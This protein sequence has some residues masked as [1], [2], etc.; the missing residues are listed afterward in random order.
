MVGYRN[1]QTL[2]ALN[3][4]IGTLPPFNRPLDRVVASCSKVKRYRAVTARSSSC[5]HG[6]VGF[7]CVSIVGLITASVGYWLV[8]AR[9]GK[10]VHPPTTDVR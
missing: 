5:S 3:L 7:Y 9:P 2:S 6:A 1:D 10:S 8:N 4:P